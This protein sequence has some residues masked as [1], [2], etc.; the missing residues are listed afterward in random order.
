MATTPSTVPAHMA[1]LGAFCGVCVYAVITG[2]TRPWAAVA[3]AAAAGTVLLPAVALGGL[4]VVCRAFNVP[5]APPDGDG[6]ESR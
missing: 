3:L 5:I 4:W 6:G 2:D 1:M